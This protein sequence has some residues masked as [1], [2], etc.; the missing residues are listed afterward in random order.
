MGNLNSSSTD[1]PTSIE[2]CI[3]I[4]TA[5]IKQID[6]TIFDDE[7]I[8]PKSIINLCIKYYYPSTIMIWL[9]HIPNQSTSHQPSPIYLTDINDTNKHWSCNLYDLQPNNSQNNWWNM[10]CNAVCFAKNVSHCLSKKITDSITDHY[11]KNKTHNTYLYNYS[12][13]KLLKYSPYHIIFKSGG[14]IQVQHATD[15]CNAIIFNDIEFQKPSENN[16]TCFNWNLPNLPLQIYGNSFVYSNVYGL[17]SIGGIVDG[18]YLS[19]FYNLSFDNINVCINNKWKWHAL[20]SMHFNRYLPSSIMISYDKL[21]VIGGYN[22]HNHFLGCVECF[23]FNNKKWKLLNNIKYERNQCG[24]YYDNNINKLYIGGGKADLF[25]IRKEIEYLD[26]STNKWL[27][28]I[29]NT[30]LD[31]NTY[32]QIWKDEHNKNILCI[33]SVYNNCLEYIDLRLY[34]KAWNILY[35]NKHSI[36]LSNKFGIHNNINFSEYCKLCI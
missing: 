18:V 26:L 10:Y 3:Q 7:Y 12:I 17:L 24:I 5:Y 1:K 16:I 19:Q 25:V 32:P 36:S 14:L 28:D 11:I 35:S 22:G 23:D 4:V 27:H 6:V 2:L 30:N 21:I 29:P 9:N 31:H 33:A 15:N 8:I 34:N 13:D 20:P